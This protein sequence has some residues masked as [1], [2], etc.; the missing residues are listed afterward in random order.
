MR[1]LLLPRSSQTA[2]IAVAFHVYF[3]ADMYVRGGLRGV[4]YLIWGRE[5]GLRGVSRLGTVRGLWTAIHIR[6]AEML[7]AFLLF[8]FFGLSFCFS[9]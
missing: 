5:G 2:L 9:A 1:A 7:Y 6:G 8:D 3:G 4:F